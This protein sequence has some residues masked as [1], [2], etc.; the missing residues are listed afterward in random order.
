MCQICQNFLEQNPTFN[1][2]EGFKIVLL[3]CINDQPYI[4]L[5]KF[6]ILQKYFLIEGHIDEEGYKKEKENFC[7]SQYI[8][9]VLA[10]YEI[11]TKAEIVL[12]GFQDGQFE[13]KYMDNILVFIGFIK[14]FNGKN[15]NIVIKSTRIFFGKEQKE[16]D[17]DFAPQDYDVARTAFQYCGPSKMLNQLH[18]EK[19]QFILS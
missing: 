6:P 2:K 9:K 11:K 15:R 10:K 13:F 5:K 16:E 3:T 17:K 14:D 18:Q 7:F 8:S 1:F 12:W 4:I 19:Y